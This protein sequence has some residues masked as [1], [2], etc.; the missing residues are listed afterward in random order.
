MK[1]GGFNIDKLGDGS[2]EP[3]IEGFAI[4]LGLLDG[5]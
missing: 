2:H 3:Y 4:N 5:A 1:L